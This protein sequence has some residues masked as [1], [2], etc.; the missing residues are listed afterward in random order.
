MRCCGLRYGWGGDDIVYGRDDDDVNGVDTGTDGECADDT[1]GYDDTCEYD[2]DDEYDDTYIGGGDDVVICGMGGCNEDGGP[3][4]VSDGTGD[5]DVVDVSEYDGGIHI[6]HDGDD[7]GA[8]VLMLP[9][10]TVANTP[11]SP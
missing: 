3:G 7:T 4:D 2:V 5:C 11:S 6:A 10:I 8:S 1:D 9:L